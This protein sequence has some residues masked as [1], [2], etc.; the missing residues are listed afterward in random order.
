M[1]STCSA[2]LRCSFDSFFLTESG[3]RMLEWCCVDRQTRRFITGGC[4]IVATSQAFLRGAP[5]KC[6]IMS[7]NS[8][9]PKRA[10]RSPSAVE[11]QGA[12]NSIEEFEYLKMSRCQFTIGRL[13]F[14]RPWDQIPSIPAVLVCDDDSVNES[15]SSVLGMADRR[16]A[17]ACLVLRQAFQWGGAH[18]KWVHSRAMLAD[19]CTK[20]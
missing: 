19:I 10:A 16:S 15:E 6:S 1:I 2:G 8:S 17:I 11:I 7:W 9:K 3:L 4:V 14:Q 18:L 12:N 13:N 20:S 5:G